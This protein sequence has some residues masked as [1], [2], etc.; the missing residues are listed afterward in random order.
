MSIGGRL[1]EYYLEGLKI[2]KTNQFS[3]S[4]GLERREEIQKST[5]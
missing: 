5:E 1:R 3:V 2:R 4:T